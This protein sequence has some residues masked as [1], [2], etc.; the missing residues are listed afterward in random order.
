VVVN[1]RVDDAVEELLL[2]LEGALR[3]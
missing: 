3:G 1:E 2:L